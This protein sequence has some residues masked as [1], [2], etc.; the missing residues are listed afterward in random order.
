MPLS[1]DLTS[2]ADESHL[3]QSFSDVLI[4]K[5]LPLIVILSKINTNIKKS[6]LNFLRCVRN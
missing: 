2:I 6:M 5:N 4:E 1:H 3:L